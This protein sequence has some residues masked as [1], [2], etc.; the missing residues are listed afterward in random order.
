MFLFLRGLG[1]RMHGC[2]GIEDCG[3][4]WGGREWKRDRGWFL[5][6]RERRK[7]KLKLRREWMGGK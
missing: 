1:G 6:R 3:G 7:G 5:G 4:G 2:V